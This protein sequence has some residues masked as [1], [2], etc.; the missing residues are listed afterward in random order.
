MGQ[1]PQLQVGAGGEVH[2]AVAPALGDLAEPQQ[3]GRRQRTAHQAQAHQGA[4]VGQPRAGHP[5]A[6]VAPPARGGEGRVGHGGHSG[7]RGSCAKPVTTSRRLPQGPAGLRTRDHPARDTFPDSRPVACRETEVPPVTHTAARQSRTLTGFP[8]LRARLAAH[9]GVDWRCARYQRP[10][11]RAPH[12]RVGRVA[13]C[14]RDRV[15]VRARRHRR[16]PARPARPARPG[17]RD[18]RGPPSRPPRPCCSSWLWWPGR[19]SR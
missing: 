6:A 9:P 3:G 16:R 4:V 11:P 15:R 17:R 2:V 14:A 10:L 5:R 8:D 12:V 1:R 18:P 13:G 19:C 7:G